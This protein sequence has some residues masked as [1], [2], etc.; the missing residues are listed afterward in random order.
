MQMMIRHFGP[1]RKP[2]RIID[3]TTL[4]QSVSAMAD[5]TYDNMVTRPSSAAILHPGFDIAILSLSF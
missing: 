5:A 4:C 3:S 1:P 2:G